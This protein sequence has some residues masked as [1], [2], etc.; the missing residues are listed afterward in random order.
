M[1]FQSYNEELAIANLLFRRTFSDIRIG[2]T[3]EQG[4]EKQILVQCT[5]GQK[6][7]ILK[8]LANP[9]RRGNYKVPMIV[10]NRT[11]Y[12]RNGDRLN[13]MNNEVKYEMTSYYRKLHLM[14][15]VPVDVSYDVTV[16][17]KYPSDIDK[18]ASNFMV[19]FNSD[20]YV[21]CE[22]PK[23]KGVKLN[24]QIIMSDSITE[25][26]PDE[27]DATQDD[28]TTA[29]FQF[30]F[31]TYLFAG[32]KKAQ[33]IH[34]KVISS[35][36]SSYIE[37]EVIEINASDI[38]QFQK[39]HPGQ[40]VSATLTS[41]VTKELTAEVDN[42]DI[43]G[44]IYDDVPYINKIDFGMYVVPRSKDIQSY[45]QSVDNGLIEP[46]V[47]SSISGYISSRSY[48]SSPMTMLSDPY[49]VADPLCGYPLSI[50]EYGASY[51]KPLSTIDDYYDKVDWKC[52]L[53][54][55]VDKLY[56]RIDGVSPSAF[57]YNI[58]QEKYH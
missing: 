30:T 7:R 25:D 37:N 47:D 48:I 3:N 31:K 58:V 16:I 24:N 20:I 13:N 38:D 34:P 21:S 52:S 33:L 14:P 39:D 15:P 11:G 54:P 26:H 22:H 40:N 6:S 43:S 46:H 57:P 50:C 27:L 17:A 28:L 55:Y 45:I 12:Q 5:L 41:Y 51:D 42:P 44:L 35:F 18:I 19:F 23:Y 32:T 49:V 56:W 36:M 9:E 4:E 8:N 29:T 53:E 10:I 1:E 2:R